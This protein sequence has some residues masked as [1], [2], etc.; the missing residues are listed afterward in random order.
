LNRSGARM[1]S[2]DDKMT[3]PKKPEGQVTRI[4]GNVVALPVVHRN[5]DGVVTSIAFKVKTSSKGEVTIKAKG[6]IASAYWSLTPGMLVSATAV[7][8][9][10]KEYTADGIDILPVVPPA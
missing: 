2:G 5:V 1:V 4:K 7:E 9:G 6:A 8:T 10:D 3:D